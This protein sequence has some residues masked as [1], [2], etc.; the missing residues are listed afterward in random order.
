M[1][2][3]TVSKTLKVAICIPCYGDP[4]AKF[5]QSL[6][7]M[8]NY[9]HVSQLQDADGTPY[10][11]EVETFIVSGSMLTECRHRLIAEALA[12][13]ADWI[14]CLD[15]DHTFPP[16]TLDM[17][18]QRNLPIVGCNY[19]RRQ[20]PTAPTAAKLNS[21]GIGWE[22]LVYTTKE[23]AEANEVEE[24]S[25]L[26]MGVVLLKASIFDAL[27]YHAEQTGGSL[28][29]LFQFTTNE[30][31]KAIKGEDVWFFDKCRA[32]GVPVHCDHHVSWLVGHCMDTIITN[33][34]A[35]EHR[36]MWEKSPEADAINKFE[37]KATEIDNRA[38]LEGQAA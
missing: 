35:W 24:V 37:A 36:G 23:K 13:E 31:G 29:P 28:M 27:A 25:H 2:G 32:A 16:Q 8:V 18:L 30:T 7:N 4:K 11:K 3:D 21:V 17:L 34:T 19:A 12:W 20:I 9:F 10:V 14:L 5:M 22:N 38:R 1:K 15:A 6:L 33:A 26:G